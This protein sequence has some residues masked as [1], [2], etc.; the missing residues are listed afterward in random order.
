MNEVMCRQL[1]LDYCCNVEDVADTSNHFSIYYPAEGRRVYKNDDDTILKAAVVDGKILFSG[2]PAIIEWCREKY[3]ETK[4]EWFFEPVTI[5]ELES[6]LSDEGASIK[7]LH[8][9]YIAEHITPVMTGNYSIK[10]YEGFEIEKFR[11]DNRWDEAL[12]FSATAPDA[13][14]V[15]AESG[16]EILGMAGASIDSPMMWQIGINVVD[17]YRRR[18]IATALV[19]LLKNEILSRGKLPFYGTAFS[20]LASQRVALGSGFVPAWVEM[21]TQSNVKV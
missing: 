3:S 12:A 8:P 17:G 15:T 1:A 11:G 14:A 20:H 4:G 18:G 2:K 5:R 16:D 6:R 13:L 9:F 7:M 10:W 21:A 19:S